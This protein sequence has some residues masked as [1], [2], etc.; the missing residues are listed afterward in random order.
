MADMYV[1]LYLEALKRLMGTGDRAAQD[2]LLMSL[3]QHANTFGW[4]YPGD[5]LIGA[6]SGHRKDTIPDILTRLELMDYIHLV[7]TQT[8]RRSVPDRDIQINPYLIALRPECHDI[9]APEWLSY[10]SQ[11]KDDNGKQTI[12]ITYGRNDLQ[13]PPNHL[14]ESPSRI[15]TN[16]LPPPPPPETP[17]SVNGKGKKR[18]NAVPPN[19]VGDSAPTAQE[20]PAPT[21][22]TASANAQRPRPPF[23]ASP[24][25]TPSRPISLPDVELQKE[26]LPDELYER[27]AL[28]MNEATGRG[29]SLAVAR[30]LVMAHGTA[31]CTAATKLL[32]NK[33]GVL[34]AGGHLR[35]MIQTGALD[36]EGDTRPDSNLYTDGK[37]ADFIEH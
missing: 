4:C 1:S 36:V 20:L 13:P 10:K 32:K 14:Q 5:E 18:K 25:P 19:A 35:W 23:R 31:T 8:P 28:D 16:E 3:C 15:N 26:P 34:N 37:Y 29:M 2:V 11:T 12:P 6:E 21:A 7:Y 33:R 30:G 22:Q 24:S 27:V 9:S 17:F